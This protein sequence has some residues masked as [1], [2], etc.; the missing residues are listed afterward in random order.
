[1]A[2]E[3]EKQE[4]TVGQKTLALIGKAD[5]DAAR[6]EAAEAREER[7]AEAVREQRNADADAEERDKDRLAG[8]MTS[9][10]ADAKDQ[11]MS[12]QKNATL[13]FRIAMMSIV[14]MLAMG[15]GTA[16][17]LLGRTVD[18]DIPGVGPISVG[19]GASAVPVHVVPEP[20][21]LPTS[22]VPLEE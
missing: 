3:D 1:M 9:Q 22:P 10:L 13:W 18:T 21:P 15:L 5:A 8:L 14:G 16:A 12:A 4:R 7:M 20:A 2:E 17:I 11:R 19:G 6:A